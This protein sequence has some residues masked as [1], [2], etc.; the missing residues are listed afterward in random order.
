MLGAL[1]ARGASEGD[2]VM[3]DDLDFDYSPRRKSYVPRYTKCG[4]EL[5]AMI[6]ALH[7]S[8]NI[9]T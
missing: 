9:H 2:L 7:A 4:K 5:G 6:R 1:A 3:L 8:A